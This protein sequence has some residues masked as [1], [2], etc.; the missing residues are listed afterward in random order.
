MATKPEADL[1]PSE[2]LQGLLLHADASLA[3]ERF[4]NELAQL[5]ITISRTT[6]VSIWVYDH[7]I[8][9]IAASAGTILSSE[10][11]GLWE[12]LI[13]NEHYTEIEDTLKDVVYKFDTR[14][15]D[16]P[17]IRYLAGMPILNNQGDRVGILALS[18]SKPR[19]FSGEQI[20]SLSIISRIIAV[21]LDM[22]N[23]IVPA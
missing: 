19:K 2:K 7:A 16:Q 3:N 14:V 18:D 17:V 11:I 5:S 1:I 20:Q 10:R 4:W 15:L 6:S 8:L 13:R 22:K 9:R 21:H 23:R 12:S